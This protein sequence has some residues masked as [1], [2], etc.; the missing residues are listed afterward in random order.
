MKKFFLITLFIIILLGAGLRFYKLGARSFD[1]DEFF[2]LNTS[3]GYFKTGK[4]LAWDFN[5]EKPFEGNLQD[6]TSTERAEI[7]RWQLAQSYRF[8]E[9]SETNTR[10][11]SAVWGIISI[12]LVYFI[13][14]SFTGN[15]YIALIAAFLVAVGES[16]IIYS[17]RLRMYSM[18]FPVY[19]FFSWLVFKFYEAKYGGKIKL[20][21]MI[22]EKIGFNPVYFLPVLAVGIASYNTQV[23]TASIVGTIFVYSLVNLTAS[24]RKKSYF[25]NYS[26]T[27]IAISGAY[28]A[29]SRLPALHKFYKLAKKNLKL[30]VENYSYFSGYFTDMVFPA[31]GFILLLIGVWF[32]AKKLDRKKEAVFLFLSAA[33]P[34]AAA[35][36]TWSRDPAHRYI[37]FLQSFGIILIAVGIF[38]AIYFISGKFSK[39]R[40]PVIVITLIVFTALISFKYLAKN[41]EVYGHTKNSYYPDFTKIFS[42]ILANKKPEDVFVTRAYRSY[43]FRS[44]KIPVY[45]TQVLPLEKSDCREVLEDII[46]E[47]K[48]GWVIIPKVDYVSL[49]KDGRQYLSENLSRVRADAIPT[50]APVYRWGE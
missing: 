23:L 24:I 49:C 46:S 5:N 16:E 10:A 17:R 30:F 41:S 6:D 31:V 29:A 9:P 4:F 37:Y 42:Y 32:L 48:S 11:V 40:K 15:K 27:L 3:Y 28:L 44:Q 39:Y 1:R 22:S 35:V 45:D 21:R 19:L 7:F 36:F 50:S 47:N 14:L 20:F 13:T 43:Y 18:F 26:I 34:L 25:N 38:A 8:F 33:V 2:E 12:I